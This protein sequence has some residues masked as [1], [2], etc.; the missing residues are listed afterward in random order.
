MIC[1]Y[2]MSAQQAWKHLIANGLEVKYLL[3]TD[4]DLLS[5]TLYQLSSQPYC[6][7]LISLFMSFLIIFPSLWKGKCDRDFFCFLVLQTEE[8]GLHLIGGDT[9]LNRHSYHFKLLVNCSAK[10]YTHFFA[11]ICSPGVIIYIGTKK[12][13]YVCVCCVSSHICIGG[14]F[15]VKCE[16][17]YQCSLC[18]YGTHLNL[19]MNWVY[20][21]LQHFSDSQ[22][23]FS[24]F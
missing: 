11:V 17:F 4:M 6:C 7:D 16:H 14:N 23:S 19:F 20:R 18:L 9:G 2:L 13:G 12:R 3:L 1:Y 24:F 10:K 8:C 21:E 5:R 22:K 15:K